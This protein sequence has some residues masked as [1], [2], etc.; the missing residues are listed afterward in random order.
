M[1]SKNTSKQRFS[2]SKYSFFVYQKRN[3]SINFKPNTSVQFHRVAITYE[4]FKNENLPETP[5]DAEHTAGSELI[6]EPSNMS[7]F[8]PSNASSEVS[9]RQE[10]EESV[11]EGEKT[12]EIRMKL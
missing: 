2:K 12:N 8:E 6:D 9:G 5:R 1:N 4:R 3:N 7:S 11:K 10:T